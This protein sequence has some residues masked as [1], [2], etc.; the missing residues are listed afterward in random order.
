LRLPATRNT[1]VA[2]VTSILRIT[3]QA[4]VL[5]SE[6]AEKNATEAL[7]LVAKA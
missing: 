6:C 5:E 4:L 1:E 7:R 2:P 3:D